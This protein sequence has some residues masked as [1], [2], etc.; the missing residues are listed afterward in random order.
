MRIE[1]FPSLSG[2]E[3]LDRMHTYTRVVALKLNLFRRVLALSAIL[4]VIGSASHVWACYAVVV[5]KEASTDGSVLVGHNEQNGGR[6]ILNF[7]R[8]PRQRFEDGAVVLLR[9]G[10]TLGQVREANALLWSENPGLEFSDAYLNE[11]GVAIVSD[12][13]PTR[14]ESYQDLVNRREIRDGGIGYMLRRL[15]AQRAKT[16]KEGV[17]IAGE[18]IERFGYVDSGRT[19]IIADPNE[20]WLLSVVRGRRWVAQRVPD[21]AVVLLPNVHVIREVD[22]KD[23]NNFLA[24]SDLIDYAI[25]RGWF[26]P[27]GDEPFDFRRAYRTER[28]D[29]PDLRQYLGHRI[30]TGRYL[31]WPPKE[32]LPFAVKPARKL[33]VADLIRLLRDHR[34][35]APIC[36][37]LT[38]EAAVFQLRGDMPREIGCVYWRTTAEPCISV[39]TPWYLGITETPRCYYRPTDLNTQLSLDHHF[40]PPLGTFD[41]DPEL[42]WWKFMSLQGIVHEDYENRVKIVHP[43]WEDFEN[44]EFAEQPTVEEHV[45][46]SI[47]A[48]GNAV[49]AYLTQYCADLALEACQEADKLVDRLRNVALERDWRLK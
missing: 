43:V 16:A 21:D 48:D 33:S 22:P 28:N 12:G 10:G 19:Y 40:S 11:W 34:G 30:V 20:A 6:R 14:E 38:Q 45:L 46:Q 41:L 23:S 25:K 36:S 27:S 1:R 15:V 44:R 26:D 37:P 9:R 13:C 24:S 4:L 8:I 42:A 35:S 29:P 31:P 18:L 49:H 3:I 32:P 17:E 39:L 5:G 2:R 7:R 47:E